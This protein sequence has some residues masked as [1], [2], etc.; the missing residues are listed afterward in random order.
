M[1]HYELN[2]NAKTRI[3]KLAPMFRNPTMEFT[4]TALEALSQIAQLA[5][6]GRGVE[7][8][9]YDLKEAHP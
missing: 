1:E 6:G 3:T 7:K 2:L 4:S 8:K 5:L 9:T